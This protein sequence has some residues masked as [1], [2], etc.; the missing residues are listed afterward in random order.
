MLIKFNKDQRW[1]IKGNICFFKKD[2]QKNIND[3][4]IANDIIRLD[5]GVEVILN[6]ESIEIETK[7]IIDFNLENKIIKPKRKYTKKKIKNK[8]I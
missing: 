7:D 2:E 8:E 5:Y 4:D 1:T 3:I 6:Q